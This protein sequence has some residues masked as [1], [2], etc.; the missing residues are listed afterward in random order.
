MT[1]PILTAPTLA[2]AAFCIA[3]TVVQLASIAI[4][5]CRLRRSARQAPLSS[6]YPAVSLV[7]PLCGI[8]NYADDTLF[9]TFGLDYPHYEILFCV[10]SAND[11][12]VP[13]VQVLIAAHPAANAKLL[14]GDDRLSSNPKLNNVLKGWD[15]AKH[16]W[17]IIA[18]SN[19]LMPRDYIQRLFASWRHDTG[20]VASPPI[21]SRPQGFWAEIG[22]AVLNTYPARWQ[23]LVEGFGKGFAQ[24]KIMLWRRADLEAAGGIGG[25]AKETA[26]D[27]AATK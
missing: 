22:C 3:V 23:Y 8:D 26:E 19:V 1:A 15:A 24:G 13:L 6:L 27:A 12:V 5:I 2:V 4:A 10:A 18:D 11:P 20:L 7:R 9:S 16:D 17:I 21:G 14:I 25:L